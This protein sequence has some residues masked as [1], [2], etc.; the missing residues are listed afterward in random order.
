LHE[1][2]SSSSSTPY[3]ST[4]TSP[5]QSPSSLPSCSS[6]DY[7]RSISSFQLKTESMFSLESV[8]V[9]IYLGTNKLYIYIYINI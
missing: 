9:L 8:G 1:D 4:N 5:I 7:R 6:R 2:S 3:Y